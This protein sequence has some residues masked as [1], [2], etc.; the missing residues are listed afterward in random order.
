MRKKDLRELLGDEVLRRPLLQQA[1]TH[2]SADKPHNERLEFFGD[3]VLGLLISQMLYDAFS[4]SVEGE[5]SRM[6]SHLVRRETLAAIAQEIDLSRWMTMG[7]G[8]TRSGGSRKLA[9]LANALEAV[10]GSLYLEFGSETT[11]DFVREIYGARVDDLPSGEDLKDPK[12]KLQEALQQRGIE[13]PIYTLCGRQQGIFEVSCEVKSLSG[14][15][16]TGTAPT[17]RNAEQQAAER[18]LALLDRD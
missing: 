9:L 7:H 17:K 10:I 1:L 6:R 4:K 15:K 18:V 16:A 14:I 8:E 2:R 12:S 13:L 11:T 3:A 5:L